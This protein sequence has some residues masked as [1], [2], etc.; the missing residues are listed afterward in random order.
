MHI[1][2][3]GANFMNKGAELMVLAILQKTK[4]A[5]PDAN[6]VMAPKIGDNYY[7]VRAK[8]GFL[9]KIWLHRYG[10]QWGNFGHIIPKK[11]R[12]AYGLVP[13]CQVNV[14]LDASGFLYGDQWGEKATVAMARYLK[15]WKKNGTK[16]ILLPQAMGPFTS[17]KIRN[18]FRYIAEN[19]DLIFPRDNISYQHVVNLAGKRDN[20]IQ[21]P[22]FTISVD[23]VITEEIERFRDLYCIVPNCRM[24]DKTSDHNGDIYRSFCAHCIEYLSEIGHKPFILIHEGDRDIELARQIVKESGENIEIFVEHDALKIKGIIGISAGLIGSRYH[25]LINALSQGVP[26]LA[27][28]WSHKYSMLFEEYGLRDGCLQLPVEPSIVK[29][30]I[31]RMVDENSR[32]QIVTTIENS[33]TIIREQTEL[34]WQKVILQIKK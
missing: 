20:I 7:Q 4:E 19:T 15:K 24:I 3:K 23:G 21:M 33:A 31:D 34:M 26:S 30:H 32:Q 11:I 16:V 12:R 9:Q 22:D 17:K 10:I 6:F 1:E 8:M 27:T 18:S 5:F 29:T 25:A 13:D 2:I 14:V 28:G